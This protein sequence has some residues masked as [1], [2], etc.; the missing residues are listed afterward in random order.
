MDEFSIETEIG[1][2]TTVTMRKW[3]ERDELERLRERSRRRG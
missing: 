3:R 1:R 2:G